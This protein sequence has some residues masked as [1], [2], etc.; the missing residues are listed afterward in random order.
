M[1][2]AITRRAI[3]N[4]SRN[5]IVV[6]N[7]VLDGSTAETGTRVNV[8]TGDM[9]T[10]NKVVKLVADMPT[11]CN[12]LWDATTDVVFQAI[13]AN[14]HTEINYRP[15]GGI[16]NNAGTGKTGDILL[17]TIGNGTAGQAGTLT[18]WVQKK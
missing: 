15:Q 12:L 16:V 13:E 2:N 8:T 14:T 3:L 11:N 5:Y 6:F 10:D 17:T 4:G 7:I 18:V 9:G 1:A